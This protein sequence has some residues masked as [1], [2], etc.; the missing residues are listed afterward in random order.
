MKPSQVQN[1][2]SSL[3]L[4]KKM[5]LLQSSKALP[6]PNR[7]RDSLSSL[8]VAKPVAHF[9]NNVFRGQKQ[10][11]QP[12]SS[13]K[14]HPAGNNC[15]F[16]KRCM[17]SERSDSNLKKKC[18]QNTSSGTIQTPNCSANQS[19]HLSAV[20]SSSSSDFFRLELSPKSTNNI[21]TTEPTFYRP[22][23]LTMPPKLSP[24]VPPDSPST[25]NILSRLPG[26]RKACMVKITEDY[27]HLQS[28]NKSLKHGSLHSQVYSSRKGVRSSDQELSLENG[29]TTVQDSK[30]SG[31]STN[32]P[33]ASH[34]PYHSQCSKPAA[35]VKLPSKDG[36]SG[37]STAKEIG[38]A[39]KTSK[40]AAKPKT[41]GPL[42]SHTGQKK[43]CIR[44]LSVI[45]D[46]ISDLFT[47]DPLTYVS[48]SKHK[49]VV[50]PAAEQVKPGPHT[51]EADGVPDSAA[52]SR[53]PTAESPSQQKKHS[54]GTNIPHLTASVTVKDAKYTPIPK[55]SPI[56]RLARL[57]M[58]ILWGS[59]PDSGLKIPV[60]LPIEQPNK[61]DS[62]PAEV[63][64][65][66]LNPENGT[67]TEGDASCAADGTTS[68]DP[69]TSTLPAS[70][71][72][73]DRGGKMVDE[74]VLG[75][76][77]GFGLDLDESESS[78]S[79]EDEE[80]IFLQEMM[81]RV[82]KPPEK[83]A[84][85]EPT[86]PISSRRHT[87]PNTV[88]SIGVARF[89]L[90]PLTLNCRNNLDQM[91]KEIRCIK[92][93]KEKEKKLLSTCKEE[94][95]R[96]A[97]PEENHDETI[98]SEQEEFL[99]RFPV[100]SS[101][102]RDVH[103]GEVVFNLESSGRLFSQHTLQLRH[104]KANPQGIAQKTLLWSSPAQLSLHIRSGLFQDAYDYSPCPP[105]VT[106]FLFKMMSVHTERMISD[107]ILQA[108][109]DIARSAANHIGN[110]NNGNQKFEVWVPSVADVTVVL[111]N[112]GASFVTLFPLENFQPPFKEGDLLED[113]DIKSESPSSNL[114]LSTIPKHNYSNVLKTS[115]HLASPVHASVPSS[116]TQYLSYC[117]ALCPRAF[118]DPELLL[119]LTLG[120]RLGLEARFTL[121]PHID[122]RCL[123]R[124]IIRN[125]RDWE[126]T[127]S[128]KPSTMCEPAGLVHHGIYS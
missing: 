47:P 65:T 49:E 17:D 128:G 44:R 87:I 67:P 20:S 9:Q 84:Y 52:T 29:G 113:M 115:H 12:A 91:L 93:S 15:L 82:A 121:E 99:R 97:E 63:H 96:K 101:A 59:T 74:D 19:Q 27:V 90:T 76:D 120:S 68:K 32:G 81:Q 92:R 46:D 24:K 31:S 122:L 112:M 60:S 43:S 42:R 83:R 126:D 51:T 22:V 108:L 10:T 69:L 103:P 104:C 33:L 58:N 100:M 30:D 40:Q 48:S 102:I 61:Y 125:V 80:L 6:P 36:K 78:E 117:M 18:L 55:L 66:P 73:A 98:S 71:E 107:K 21:L 35:Q 25:H 39:C 2:L 41:T 75:L 105:Q 5:S 28:P 119:L 86:T 56:V 1:R 57:N 95:L 50:R 127:V 118:S 114:K 53:T 45:P 116:R 70:K 106:R 62:E 8:N 79:S 109:C 26:V 3:S 54:T 4:P 111:L 38:D 13:V 94:D 123:Q 89:M 124:H 85:T 14:L 23:R 7:T 37:E 77:L 110:V 88:S 16:L 64:K 72:D 11:A 34:Q